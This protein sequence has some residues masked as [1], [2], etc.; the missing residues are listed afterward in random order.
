[1]P[2][3]RVLVSACLLGRNCRYDGDNKIDWHLLEKLDGY[4]IVAFCP[5]ESLLGSPRETI[6]IVEDRAI[7]NESGKDYTKELQKQ[8]KNI[9]E[10]YDGFDIIY[11]KSKSPS[12]AL[13]SAK[14]YDNEK[15]LIR[16]DGVGIVAK[17]LQ[18]LY[19]DAKFVEREGK[20]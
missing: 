12:C 4:E 20:R 10:I 6:D 3:R 7:G 5:E 9:K 17:E 18:K 1:M 8:A 15:C 14:V 19:K 2:K 11:L 16:S 13:Q